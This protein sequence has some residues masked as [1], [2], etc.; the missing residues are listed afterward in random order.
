MYLLTPLYYA[1][2]FHL[3]VLYV[4]YMY[5]PLQLVGLTQGQPIQTAVHLPIYHFPSC[6]HLFVPSLHLVRCCKS[7]SSYADGKMK[8][9]H[10]H[11]EDVKLEPNP[12]YEELTP[13][14]ARTEPMGIG[15]VNSSDVAMKENPAYQA[16]EP[17]S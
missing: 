17:Q 5:A 11:F 15:G 13:S 14:Q 4:V 8:G 7:S 2:S 10:S 3:K 9:V 12:V 16:T 1:Y 6:L